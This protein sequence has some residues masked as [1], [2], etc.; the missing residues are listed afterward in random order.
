MVKVMVRNTNCEAPQAEFI[1]VLTKLDQ[2]E[3][4][5]PILSDL[6]EAQTGENENKARDD[7]PKSFLEEQRLSQL[8]SGWLR[9]ELVR[10]VPQ[11][12]QA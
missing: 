9:F 2:Q 4:R 7:D 11:G 12:R 6:C 1:R 5:P 3:S 8:D 10:N